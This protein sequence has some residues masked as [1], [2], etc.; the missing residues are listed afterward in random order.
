MK[1]P[2]CGLE[3]EEML[4]YY[5]CDDCMIGVDKND[6]TVIISVGTKREKINIAE[7][8]E[9]V[10]ENYIDNTPEDNGLEIIYND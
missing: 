8:K 6:T 1:C 7:D 9:I 4:L 2:L 10:E 5:I 3:M